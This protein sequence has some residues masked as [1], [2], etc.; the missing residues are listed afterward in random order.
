MVINSTN[1]NKT[2]KFTLNLTEFTEHKKT[3]TFGFGNPGPGL[4]LGHDLIFAPFIDSVQL[5]PLFT[6]GF[7]CKSHWINQDVLFYS[8]SSHF[9]QMNH[10]S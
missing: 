4:G 7:K 10:F 1:I 6:S 2:N 9:V 8:A 3:T 5:R